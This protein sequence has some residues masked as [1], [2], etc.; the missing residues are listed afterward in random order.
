MSRVGKYPVKILDGVTVDV[1]G[2]LVKVKGPKGEL[3]RAM[4]EDVVIKK[5]D[6]GIEVEPK[7]KERQT[8]MNWATSRA[9]INNMVK[10]VKDGYQ[11]KMEIRGVG[12][13]ASMQGSILVLNVG[14]SHEVKYEAPK[15]VQ[16]TVDKQVNISV[17][18]IDK[19]KVGQTAAEIVAI[20]PPEPY[21]GKGIRYEGQYILMKEGKKK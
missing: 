21:K 10:G 6:K 5:T 17:S 8:R 11:K 15:G 14:F 13:R 12:L 2:Q 9:H 7:S 3:A 16:I 20:K 19:E 4:P 18:G 1:Q